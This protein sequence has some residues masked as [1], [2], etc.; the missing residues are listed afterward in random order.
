MKNVLQEIFRRSS[1]T[2]YNSTLLFPQRVRADVTKLYAFVRVFDD[3]VDSTPQRGEEFRD[4]RRKYYLQLRG[5]DTGDPVLRNFVELSQRK[6]FREE[7]VEAFLDSME[8]DLH[9]RIYFTLEETLSYM[10]GSAEVVGLMM[11]KILG[12]PEQA[13]PY[14]KALGRAMQYLNFVRDVSEDRT[15]GR[16]YLPVQDMDRFGLDSLDTCNE[17]FQEFI[18]FNLGRYFSYQ[19]EAERGYKFIPL[20]YLI[21]IKT[22]ADMYKWTGKLIYESP[23]VVLRKKVKPRRERVIMTG[24]YNALKVS[25][26]SL[27]YSYRI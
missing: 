25:V 17:G 11:M 7:W 2:Y 16:Q 21:P 23:C 6:G 22:A 10:Y 20:R 14:A 4:M 12:L 13:E 19:E 24:V 5:R 15:M 3:L 8:S 1:V 27:L 9:K 26:W 18:R